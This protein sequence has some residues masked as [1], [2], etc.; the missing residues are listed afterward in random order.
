MLPRR[1]ALDFRDVFSKGFA[2]D[3]IT[4]ALHIEKGVINTSDFKMKGPAAEV[5][6]DGDADIAA[7]TQD[8]K[9]RV[10][11]ALGDSASTLLG[12][13]NPLYGVAT[14][15]AQKLLKNP[16]GNIFAF[17]YSVTGKWADPKVEKLAVTPV[18][19]G[20]PLR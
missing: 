5:D 4:S 9:V 15:I 12:L 16:I 2:F 19:P 10:V 7:E 13:V 6:I 3:R 1:I 11:P 18:E 20:E 8:L 14:F 17:E